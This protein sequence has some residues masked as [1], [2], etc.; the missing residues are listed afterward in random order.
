MN[1]TVVPF[2]LIFLRNTR[3]YAKA[4]GVRPGFRFW[5]RFLW[6]VF[7]SPGFWRRCMPLFLSYYLPGF[8]PRNSDDA[9]LVMKGRDWIAR[10]MP[11]AGAA[12]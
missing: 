6:V 5:M 12:G 8:D 11:A 4:D 1:A 9:A 7:V 2:L 10:E 3:L